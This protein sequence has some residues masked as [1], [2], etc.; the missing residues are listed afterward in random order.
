MVNDFNHVNEY[1]PIY[2]QSGKFYTEF[3]HIIY[4]FTEPITICGLVSP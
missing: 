4:F 1:L 2:F 3:Q